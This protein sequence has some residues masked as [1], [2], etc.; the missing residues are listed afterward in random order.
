MRWAHPAR[1]PLGVEVT[2]GVSCSGSVVESMGAREG[3][4]VTDAASS[5]GAIDP[6]DYVAATDFLLEDVFN[7]L[8]LC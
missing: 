8:L 3:V 6:D 7:D 2:L 5:P 4:E 1:T